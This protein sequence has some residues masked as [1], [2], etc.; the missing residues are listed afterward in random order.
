MKL[1]T[2]FSDHLV[3]QRDKP[4]A[5]W[6]GAKPGDT[7]TVEFAGQRK[8]A[9]AG[10]DGRW[11]VNLDPLPASAEPCELRVSSPGAAPVTIRDVLVG[12]V[13]L[14]SGQSNMEWV[15]SKSAN[16]AAEMAAAN[17]PRL[18]MFNVTRRA[19][20]TVEKDVDGAWQVCTPVTVEQ[21][22]AIA[23]FFGREIHRELHVPVGL[24]NS[25]W[26]GTRIEAWTSRAALRTY[27]PTK[28]E[29]EEYENGP[30]DP[31]TRRRWDLFAKDPV[32]YERSFV[33]ADPGNT[34]FAKGWAT[35]DFDDA[36]WGEMR[37][38][39]KWQEHGHNFSGVFWFRRAVEVPAAWAGQDLW[40]HLG[41]CDK[42]DTTYFNGALVGTMGWG[43]PDTWCTPRE[44]RVPGKLVHAGRNVITTR[45]Y[46]YMTDGG[47]IGPGWR[48]QLKPA[49]DN[50]GAPIPLTGNWRFKI[51]HK[52]GIV[53]APQYP[54][55]PGNANTPHILFDSML[56]PLAPFGLR[57]ALWYQGESN[58]D[59]AA[60]YRALFPLMIRD[61][62]RVFG[63]GNFPFLFVQLANFT[64]PQ[65]KPSE[66]GWA[67]LREAQLLTLREPHTGMAV[68]ID[69]GAA[70]D[71][72]PQDKQ[73]V[74]HRLALIALAQIHGKKV[75]FSGPIYQS[76]T[77]T[78]NSIRLEFNHVAGGLKTSDG[79]PLK[80]FAIAGK[81][82]NFVW[83]DA[84]ITGH[85]VLVRSKSVPKPVAVRYSWASNPPGNLI[86]AARLP[87]S[88]FRTD[89]DAES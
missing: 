10:N 44:Y 3:L 40:L 84:K 23:Y 46:S 17:Y 67:G 71:I 12:E 68:T 50:A 30:T 64:D 33:P 61:W 73:T 32:A 39:S 75:E 89:P 4:A 21:F 20:G 47:L 41:A 82:K 16:A 49:T 79:G 1:S 85:S 45:I 51:E 13:W 28:F 37:T 42:H 15:V 65:V 83:A 43:K 55:G 6:G 77:V 78:G 9:V 57:G 34:G 54:W 19:P 53:P 29:I 80:G 5:I 63:Q 62:R 35:P 70:K 86:N 74:G 8:T 58:A 24:I 26:G 2:L 56:Q 31:E 52:F 25:S 59:K 38:P 36:G 11:L 22:S 7:V 14:A 69:V 66:G 87:A 27:P 76:H 18:R 60:H 88:P 81:D 48:M 72:H